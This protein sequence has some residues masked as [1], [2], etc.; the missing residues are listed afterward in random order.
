MLQD[1]RIDPIKR[2]RGQSFRRK[3][4]YRQNST[5][6]HDHCAACWVKF[7]LSEG[8]LD[9]GYAISAEY[10]NGEDSEWVCQQCFNELCE[11]MGWKI[12]E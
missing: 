4:Y 11:L 3:K 12:I 2:L 10:K 1:S 8:C 9:Q 7:M 6:D 5:W